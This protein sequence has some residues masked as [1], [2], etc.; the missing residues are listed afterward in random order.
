MNK[1]RRTIFNINACVYHVHLCYTHFQQALSNLT[2]S[3]IFETDYAAI[4]I[5]KGAPARHIFVPVHDIEQL[6]NDF[7]ASGNILESSWSEQQNTVFN[8]V[9]DIF[10]ITIKNLFKGKFKGKSKIFFDYVANLVDKFYSIE[11]VT[12]AQFKLYNVQLEI[13]L[14][15]LEQLYKIP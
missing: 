10:K 2:S 13:I 4:V 5:D 9:A 11:N 3:Y 7:Y 15:E 8:F 12:T 14:Q 1:D 6:R